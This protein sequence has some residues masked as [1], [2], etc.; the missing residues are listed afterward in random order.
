MFI[1][2]STALENKK[3]DGNIRQEISRVRDNYKSSIRIVCLR[4]GGRTYQVV[5]LILW[6][7]DAQAMATI[8]ETITD[9]VSINIAKYLKIITIKPAAFSPQA[10]KDLK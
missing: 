8:M 3:L 2:K 6:T 10:A 7:V 4:F 9:K 1:Q 5:T